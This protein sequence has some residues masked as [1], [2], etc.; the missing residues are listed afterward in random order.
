M[1]W[2]SDPLEQPPLSIEAFYWCCGIYDIGDFHASQETVAK[3]IKDFTETGVNHLEYD[4]EGDEDQLVRKS[5]PGV[6]TLAEYQWG[7][8]EKTLLDNGF[9]QVAEWKNPNTDRMV[10][11]YI[12]MPRYIGKLEIK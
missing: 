3:Q 5:F 8:Y 12:F 9:K 1:S 2:L 10:R 7:L 6:A 11:M 4:E